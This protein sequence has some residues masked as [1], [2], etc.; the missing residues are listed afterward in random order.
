VTN[1][2]HTYYLAIALR[3]SDTGSVPPL[4]TIAASE[5]SCQLACCWTVVGRLDRTISLPFKT[6]SCHQGYPVKAASAPCSHLS[7][8]TNLGP[9][10]AETRTPH[11]QSAHALITGPAYKIAASNPSELAGVLPSNAWRVCPIPE[12]RPALAVS[13]VDN[14][15]SSPTTSNPDQS[16]R[17]LLS[18]KHATLIRADH[19][20]VPPS[21][22]GSCQA[23]SQ[24]RANAVTTRPIVPQRPQPCKLTG[25]LSQSNL[26]SDLRQVDSDLRIILVAPPQ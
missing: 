12:E 1:F 3:G 25:S 11:P 4:R 22:S 5:Q 20:L 6:N 21:D 13:A 24:P 2:N 23:E 9:V 8:P 7:N 26:Y 14:D 15:E 10:T 19:S 16:T 18:N 17:S